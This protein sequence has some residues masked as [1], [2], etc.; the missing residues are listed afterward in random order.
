M[1]RKAVTVF[2]VAA[3][4]LLFTGPVAGAEPLKPSN[5]DDIKG[6]DFSVPGGG[7]AAAPPEERLLSPERV[8]SVLGLRAMQQ[9][10]V[11]PRLMDSATVVDPPHCASALLPGEASTYAGTN[12]SATATSVVADNDVDNVTVSVKQAIVQLPSEQQAGDLVI[13]AARGWKRCADQQVVQSLPSAK[14]IWTLGAVTAVEG[15]PTIVLPQRA[16]VPGMT[17]E[18]A[19]SFAGRDVI[20]VISCGYRGASVAGNAVKV[21]QALQ[22][23]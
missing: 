14:V 15:E 8:A 13:A 21:V 20:D 9:L 12:Y 18:R 6:G 7:A 1:V 10:E 11:E 5:L 19:L 2:I 4:A 3:T 17:C 22:A 23:G 16:D